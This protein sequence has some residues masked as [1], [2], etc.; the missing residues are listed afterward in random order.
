MGLLSKFRKQKKQSNYKEE[1]LENLNDLLNT[2]MGFG[3]YPKDLGLDSYIYLGSDRK[4]VLQIIADIKTCL[5][6]YEK[7][8][9]QL[10]VIHVPSEN[11]FFVSFVIKCKIDSRPCSFHL[12]FHQKN[13]SYSLEVKE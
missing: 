10:E 9:H 2:K 13:K 8:I 6:K 12:S 7:R 5:E 3:S 11:H 1:I 4:I